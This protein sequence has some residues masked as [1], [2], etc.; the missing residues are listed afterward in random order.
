MKQS[1]GV[2]DPSTLVDDLDGGTTTATISSSLD[3][4]HYEIDLVLAKRHREIAAR[5]R[6]SAAIIEGYRAA[7]RHQL[8]KPPR[9]LRPLAA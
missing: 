6:V 5:V 8:H 1:N 7:G 9:G 2:Q 4:K 3:G